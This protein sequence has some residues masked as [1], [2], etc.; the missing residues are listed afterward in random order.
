MTVKSLR[1]AFLIPAS[2][3]EIRKPLMGFRAAKSGAFK[4][5]GMDRTPQ[6]QVNV[7]GEASIK[8]NDAGHSISGLNSSARGRTCISYHFRKDMAHCAQRVRP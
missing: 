4:L 3:T 2:K 8:T 1:D 5:T 6:I 7:D